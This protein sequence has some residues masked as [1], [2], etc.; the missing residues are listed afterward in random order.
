[1]SESECVSE[2]VRVSEWVSEWVRVCRNQVA[3]LG[4]V[5]LGHL[6]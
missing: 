2:W 1:M 3:A 6:L 4:D 5:A